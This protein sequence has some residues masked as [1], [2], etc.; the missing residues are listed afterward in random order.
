MV[1]LY[2][3]GFQPSNCHRVALRPV[4]PFLLLGAIL[5]VEREAIRGEI[6]RLAVS[7]K[8]AKVQPGLG[9]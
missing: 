9:A 2:P 1:R 6:L 3:R 4:G 8:R 7:Y 5:G